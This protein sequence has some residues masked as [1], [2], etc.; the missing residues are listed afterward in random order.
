ME[1]PEGKISESSAE[2]EKKTGGNGIQK[3]APLYAGPHTEE[4]YATAVRGTEEMFQKTIDVFGLNTGE[5][6]RLQ[7]KMQEELGNLKNRYENR[8]LAPSIFVDA[9]YEQFVPE[10]FSQNPFQYFETHGVNVKSGE[11]VRDESGRVREDP[12][13]VKDMEWRSD[14]GEI[15][16]VVGKRVNSEKGQVRKTGN[17]LHE[18]NAM[19]RAEAFGL[20]GARPIAR[21]HQENGDLLV[22]ERIQ[23]MRLP[24][25]TQWMQSLSPGVVSSI[26][27]QVAAR[28]EQMKPQFERAGIQ[29]EWNMKDM[30]I[31]V[32]P[33]TYAVRSVIPTDW[34]KTKLIDPPSMGGAS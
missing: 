34:E 1:N 13:A 22:M 11:M 6:A 28:V 30:V 32:D 24:E 23:G 14:K 8:P 18:F 15:L 26:Q 17:P 7:Q 16:A 19:A 2:G 33:H 25:L 27:N 20:P 21:A 5:G 10:E 4:E 3:D 29:R 9:R 31:D 12:T